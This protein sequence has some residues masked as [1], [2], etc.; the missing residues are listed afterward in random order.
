M[1]RKCG[2]LLS[3]TGLGL[4]SGLGSAQASVPDTTCHLERQ[5]RIDPATLAAATSTPAETYRFANGKLYISSPD[6]PEYIYNTV[7]EVEFGKRYASGHKTFIFTGQAFLP[8]TVRM[9][10]VH[11]DSSDIR[12][13]EFSCTR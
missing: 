4:L 10:A 3:L 7:N 12:V 6:R 11:H 1:N 2:F 5:T 8:G 9:L 13:S